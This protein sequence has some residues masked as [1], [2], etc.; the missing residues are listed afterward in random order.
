MAAVGLCDGGIGVVPVGLVATAATIAAGAVAVFVVGGA[1]RLS[2]GRV[3]SIPA[4]RVDSSLPINLPC[5]G[6]IS[7]VPIISRRL[8]PRPINLF[9]CFLFVWLDN[10]V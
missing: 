2:S 9:L 1:G 6:K 7:L 10:W 5:C 3:T 8:P 4:H